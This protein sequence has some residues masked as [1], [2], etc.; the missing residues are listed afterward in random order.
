MVGDVRI[1]I[2]LDDDPDAP[3][4]GVLQWEGVR[5]DFCGWVELLRL[6][7]TALQHRPTRG[8]RLTT[9]DSPE[10]NSSGLP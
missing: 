1:I 4:A 10:A 9:R 7:E 5:A 6:L 2:E 8:S 3:P